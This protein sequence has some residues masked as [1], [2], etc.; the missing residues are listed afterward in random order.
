MLLDTL[1]ELV[2]MTKLAEYTTIA[3][4]NNTFERLEINSFKVLH[5]ALKNEQKKG[6]FFRGQAS[7]RW[8]IFSSIQR[9]WIQKDL[10]RLF[11]NSIDSFIEDFLTFCREK[12]SVQILTECKEPYD[13]SILSMLQHY[14]SPTPL[15]DFTSNSDIALFFAVNGNNFSTDD[16][17]DNFFSIYVIEAGGTPATASYNDLTNFEDI[18]LYAR[19]KI[20]NGRISLN[21]EEAKAFQKIDEHS[22]KSLDSFS[23]FSIILI[24]ESGEEFLKISNQRIDLQEGLFLYQGKNST[25][26]FESHFSGMTTDKI[27]DTYDKLLL[28]KIKV[29]DIHRA[30]LNEAKKYLEAKNITK[31]SLGLTG[32]EFGKLAFE[33]YLQKLAK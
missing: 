2:T 28:P 25:N 13:I 18:M 30:V 5:D 20:L 24:Q 15:V 21:P 32:D 23:D 17:V 7:A 26:C 1:L 6:K 19:Q 12:L 29:Y 10:N 27:I 11:H 16:E 31:E 14:G 3:E 8:K 33:S 22:M 9:E 4:R